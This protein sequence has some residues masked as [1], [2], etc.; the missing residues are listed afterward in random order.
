MIFLCIGVFFSGYFTLGIIQKWQNSPV[1]MSVGT[2][3]HHVAKLPFPAVT[4]CSVNKVDKKR[5]EKSIKGIKAVQDFKDDLNTSKFNSTMDF[6]A[7]TYMIDSLINFERA[8][9]SDP[10]WQWV[11]KNS[12]N[13]RSSDL[14]KL[15]RSVSTSELHGYFS[16]N[17]AVS[18]YLAI[19]LYCLAVSLHLPFFTFR[20]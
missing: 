11:V 1:F 13:I 10:Y 8:N 6:E 14:L 19:C 12:P 4:I 17:S 5:L 18:L 3:S 9:F 20:L 16:L 2:T 15:F 7:V